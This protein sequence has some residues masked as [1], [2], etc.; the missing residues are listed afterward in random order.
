MRYST[1]LVLFSAFCFLGLVAGCETDE[2]T[3]GPP[4]IET[5]PVTGKV[6]VN[7]QPV[8]FPSMVNVR[9]VKTQSIQGLADDT[10]S[11]SFAGEDGVFKIGTY[12]ISDGAPAGEY[13]LTFEV[14][15]MN[16]LKQQFRGGLLKNKYSDPA[17]SQWPVTVTAADSGGIDLGTI[18]LTSP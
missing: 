4:R 18:E 13:R 14:G 16:L 1:S 15:S 10:D 5:Y 6:L 2:F 8:K 17:T 9:L 7:G 11:T 3:G 12:D